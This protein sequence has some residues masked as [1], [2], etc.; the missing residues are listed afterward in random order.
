MIFHKSPGRP[1]LGYHDKAHKLYHC[2]VQ[3]SALN[4][5]GVFKG[6]RYND[7]QIREPYLPAQI[8]TQSLA[9]SPNS[10]QSNCV[11]SW[12]LGNTL[13]PRLWCSSRFASGEGDRAQIGLNAPFFDEI[14]TLMRS[15]LLE[16]THCDT[17]ASFSCLFR[18]ASA[19]ITATSDMLTRRFSA[20]LCC[21]S[22]REG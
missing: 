4:P 13:K 10:Q 21:S 2:N 12:N 9:L 17:G 7:E 6:R 8:R 20:L 16:Q 15:F 14:L 5:K 1:R 3:A 19:P 18:R 11:K 22:F